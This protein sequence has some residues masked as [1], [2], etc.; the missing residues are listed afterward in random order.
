[1]KFEEQNGRL[2]AVMVIIVLLPLVY[3]SVKN[4]NQEVM[5][6]LALLCFG[7]YFGRGGSAQPPAH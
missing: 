6:N 2:Q 5:A 4:N 7:F 3:M 1:M